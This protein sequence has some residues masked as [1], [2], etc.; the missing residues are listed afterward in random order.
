MVFSTTK[1]GTHNTTPG[2]EYPIGVTKVGTPGT[3][4]AYI[5]IELSKNITP[6][7]YYYCSNHACMGNT[8]KGAA[9]APSFTPTATIAPTPTPTSS[10]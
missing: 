7:L 6:T 5:K 1:D 2:N 4:G 3:D 9:P 10:S 8:C